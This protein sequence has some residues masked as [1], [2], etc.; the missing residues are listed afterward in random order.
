MSEKDTTHFGYK[1]VDKDAK[2][3]M[4]ADVFHSVASRYDLMNDLMSGGIHRI[5]KRFTIELSGV[6]KGNSVL[7]IA[8]GTGD[9]AARFADIVGPGG[10]VVLADINDSMLQVGRDK[11]LDNGRQAN[12]EFVQAD[13]QYLPFPDDSFDCITI[14]FGLRNVTDKDTALRSMLRVLKPGGRL[15][16]L[17]F[18]KPEN[19]L[20]SKAYDTYS[21][22][23]LP[24]MGRLVAN[25]SDSYQ[26][27][28]ESIRMH[29]DQDTLKDMMED[30]GFSRCEYHNMTG[31]VV[32]L[33]KGV[34]A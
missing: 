1:E 20:L 13:A 26:Y 28:A 12:L 9:L 21:F 8:G 25:D 16:I 19:Q 24:M 33:H 29:P 27:L 2:A 15:L 32:A 6:R 17:E 23:V 18:S 31:G 7:D 22:R 10:R 4:V 30:A 5:W 34:K 14:A 11:L 3:G